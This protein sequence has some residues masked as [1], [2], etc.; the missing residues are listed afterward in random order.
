MS[1]W[2]YTVTFLAMYT[3]S[4]LL[5]LCVCVQLCHMEHYDGNIYI[6]Y[7][8]GNKTSKLTFCVCTVFIFLTAGY[9]ENAL[10][11]ALF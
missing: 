6:K 4:L 9:C 2:I 7:T 1:K 5:I 8:M 10:L 11:L 3:Q